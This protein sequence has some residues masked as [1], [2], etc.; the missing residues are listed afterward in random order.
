MGCSIRAC[1]LVGH[2]KLQSWDRGNDCGASGLSLPVRIQKKTC[3]DNGCGLRDLAYLVA[4][5]D[6]AS[7]PDQRLWCCRATSASWVPLKNYPQNTWPT[8]CGLQHQHSCC[9]RHVKP[10][11]YHCVAVGRFLPVGF[12]E[13]VFPN[14]LA[15]QLWTATSICMPLGCST[16]LK[17]SF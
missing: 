3:S 13:T 7:I 4:C 1:A 6:Q 12:P 8:S 16:K 15:Y 2:A 11:Q 14:Y 10:Q 5:K 9:F 17:P